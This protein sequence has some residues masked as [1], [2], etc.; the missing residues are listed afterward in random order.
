MVAPSLYVD[1]RLGEFVDYEFDMT[2]LGE[3]MSSYGMSDERIR[4]ITVR[5]GDADPD[6]RKETE[7]SGLFDGE[8]CSGQYVR[9]KKEV[10]IYTLEYLLEC[11]ADPTTYTFVDEPAEAAKYLQE[12]TNHILLHEIGHSI[13]HYRDERREDR[14]FYMHATLVGATAIMAA[15]AGA[16]YVLGSVQSDTR[17]GWRGSRLFEL[18]RR[19]AIAGVI[20]SVATVIAHRGPSELDAFLCDKSSRYRKISYDRLDPDE[21]FARKFAERHSGTELVRMT[22]KEGS[23]L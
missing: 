16:G 13:F 18:A 20:G 10:E 21:R 4:S 14:F 9:A 2:K 15:A 5:M 19:G 17:L 23:D 1:E 7:A 11:R 8:N 6:E 22:L 12:E 3:L